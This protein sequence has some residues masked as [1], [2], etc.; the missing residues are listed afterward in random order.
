MEPGGGELEAAYT[1]DDGSRPLLR[2]FWEVRT[3]L[4]RHG[5][6]GNTEALLQRRHSP[7]MLRNNESQILNTKKI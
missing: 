2:T 4:C 1:Q 6:W 5:V 3:R 7:E